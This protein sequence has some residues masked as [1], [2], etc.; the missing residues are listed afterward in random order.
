MPL[1]RPIIHITLPSS[2]SF[3]TTPFNLTPPNATMNNQLTA[4][5]THITS[6]SRVSHGHRI[7]PCLDHPGTPRP[8]SGYRE[9]PGSGEPGLTVAHHTI[10]G[11][12]PAGH[13]PRYHCSNLYSVC[14]RQWLFSRRAT[15]T[16]NVSIA[17][18]HRN[19]ARSVVLYADNPS[20]VNRFSSYFRQFV[21]CMSC[22]TPRARRCLLTGVHQ[23][24]DGRGNSYL[25]TNI[26]NPDR[27]NSGLWRGCPSFRETGGADV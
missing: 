16:T 20:A 2:L 21:R 17:S 5:A 4:P 25:L 22:Y 7:F 24:P 10:I 1:T 12:Y 18:T 11:S 8:A 14:L 9:T 3:P 26:E 27:R 15:P 13:P 19:E 23:T 6:N